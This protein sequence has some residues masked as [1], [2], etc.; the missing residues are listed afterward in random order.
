[1]WKNISFN[2]NESKAKLFLNNNEVIDEDVKVH[3]VENGSYADIPFITI[4]EKLNFDIE[5]NDVN[6]AY[7]TYKSNIFI[8]DLEN[9]SL[10]EKDGDIDDDNLIFPLIGGD[11]TRKVLYKEIILDSFTMID[12]IKEMGV[13]IDIDFDFDK[14]IVYITSKNN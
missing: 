5:W 2:T 6:L 3:Y 12:A 10:Y 4:L 7:I 9:I 1:M 14:S 11:S 8:L 13:D